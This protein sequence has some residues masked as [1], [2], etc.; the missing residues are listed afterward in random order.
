MRKTK[1]CDLLLVIVIGFVPF[2]PVVPGR[3][4]VLARGC[5]RIKI[6]K[7]ELKAKR[8]RSNRRK[9]DSDDCREE[10]VP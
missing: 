1:T 3:C 7:P 2:T 10:E 8:K 9:T 5:F 4:L 6:S